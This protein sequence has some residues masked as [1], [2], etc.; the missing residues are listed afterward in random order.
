MVLDQEG[1]RRSVDLFEG[2]GKRRHDRKVLVKCLGPDCTDRM[3]Y[4]ES[5]HIRLCPKCAKR[6]RALQSNMG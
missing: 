1:E 3:F 6:I 2:L 5:R 4:S